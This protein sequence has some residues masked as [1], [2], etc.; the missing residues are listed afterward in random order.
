MRSRTEVELTAH[1]GELAL[2]MRLRAIEQVV[3]VLERAAHKEL[4][5]REGGRHWGISGRFGEEALGRHVLD[6]K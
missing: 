1:R 4:R 3:L 2:I 6:S 5:W